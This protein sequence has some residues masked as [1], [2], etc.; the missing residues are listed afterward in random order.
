MVDRKR[1][2]AIPVLAVAGMAA[3]MLVERRAPLRRQTQREPVRSVRN[4]LMGAL[5][6]AVMALAEGPL[7]SRLADIV[8]RRRWGL[9]Q[10][11]NLPTPLRDVLAILAL[12]YTMYVW[13]VLT[14]EV[15][16]L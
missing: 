1:F 8:E 15:P 16:F 14:H 3:L 4:L 7:V 2:P 10:R 9:V 11:L 5:S 12:D 6:M 13:H